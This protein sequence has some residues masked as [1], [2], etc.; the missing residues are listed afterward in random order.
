MPR[1]DALYQ[2]TQAQHCR[3]GGR[4]AT[5]GDRRPQRQQARGEEGDDDDG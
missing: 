2:S 1:P 5:E 4:H 3:R